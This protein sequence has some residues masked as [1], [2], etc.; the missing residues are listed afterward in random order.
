VFWKPR[1]ATLGVALFVWAGLSSCKDRDARPDAAPSAAAAGEVAIAVELAVAK[2]GR[3]ARSASTTGIVQ[4][5]RQAS[6]RA[7]TGGRVV[8][9]VVE[10]GQ[11]VSQ[12][13]LLVR[14]D[15]TR[16]HIGVAAARA[17]LSAVKEDLAFAEKELARKEGLAK[18]GSIAAAVLDAATYQKA[19]AE[20]GVASAEANLRSARRQLVDTR[21]VAPFD[22]VVSALMVDAG[23]TTAPGAPLISVYDLSEVKVRVGLAGDELAGLEVGSQSNIRVEDLGGLERGGEVTSIAPAASP[24]TG[25]FE[26]EVRAANAD[27]Q[28]RGGMV[29]SVRLEGG[30]KPPA[31]LVPRE[32][33]TRRG[34]HMVVFEMAEG[35]ARMHRVRVGAS[36]REFI[37]VLE[38]VDEGVTLARSALHALAEGV[39]MQPSTGAV[40]DAA[41]PRSAEGAMHAGPSGIVEQTDAP[42]DAS[43]GG[44][45]GQSQ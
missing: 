11:R 22:G 8:E 37:E 45:A 4:A 34:G 24:M 40:A 10:D 21:V 35:R 41:A 17:Q 18:S 14:I 13:D 9:L 2:R 6:L 33:V 20:A 31:V 15:D 5:A 29:A 19:K 44:A 1:P 36:D 26:V 7:E 43:S 27:G 23:D 38:G 28:V 3:I 39:A 16:Q 32:C 25:L 12:G 30:E 42:T